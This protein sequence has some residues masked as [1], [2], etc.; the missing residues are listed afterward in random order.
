MPGLCE[1]KDALHPR[2][3]N[4]E[5]QVRTMNMLDSKSPITNSDQVIVSC[6]LQEPIAGHIGGDHPPHVLLCLYVIV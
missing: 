5:T 2:A 3:M 1:E 6:S 4:N